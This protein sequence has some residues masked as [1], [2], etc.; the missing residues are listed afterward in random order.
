[1]LDFRR[2]GEYR[3]SVSQELNDIVDAAVKARR[4]AEPP[5]TYLGS[6]RL[7]DECLRRLGYEWHG[8]KAG[9]KELFSGR[10]YR[11]FARGNDCEKRV[12]ADLRAA[13]FVLQTERADG[14]QFSFAVAADPESGEPRIAGHMDGVL[15]DGPP[16]LGGV[17]LDYP[18]LWECK[19]VNN[20]SFGKFTKN[21]I[22][23]SSPVYYGQMQIYMAYTNLTWA[24]FTAEN[25]D[26]CEIYAEIV[27][28]VLA[29][30]QAVSDKG[31][32]VVSS[33]KPEE[34][35]RCTADPTDF[36]C[37]WC[38]YKEPCWATPEKAGPPQTPSWLTA[39]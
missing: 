26:T 18:G 13:G 8:L 10:L 23:K 35:P 38:P 6:S 39:A 28:F 29:D 3:K 1:M 24:L 4:D 21:G 15:V 9:K 16:S 30:A 5:R 19:G 31:V 32:R 33:L 34:L 7:G 36:R 37:S 20:K 17:T 11:I 12:A 14:H 27:P 2:S 22:K 25:Q